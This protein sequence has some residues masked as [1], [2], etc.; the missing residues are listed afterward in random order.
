MLIGIDIGTT[1]CKA[2]LCDESAYTLAVESAATPRKKDSDGEEV[3]DPKQ[4]AALIYSLLNKLSAGERPE[5]IGITGMAE[6]G[7]LLDAKSGEPRSDLLFWPDSRGKPVFERIYNAGMEQD[8]FFST[9]LHDSYKYSIHKILML[10][11]KGVDLEGSVWLSAPAYAAF[12]LTGKMYDEYTLAARTYCFDINKLS[13]D[14][15]FLEFHNIPKDIFPPAYAAGQETGETSGNPW[16]GVPVAIG[17]HDHICA[18]YAQGI[19]NE[20]DIFLSMGTAAVLL[21]SFEKRRLSKDDWNLGYS[22]GLSPEKKRMTWLASIQSAGGAVDWCCSVLGITDYKTL[23]EKMND[24]MDRVGEVLFFP[25][26]SG[27]GAPKLDSSIRG[28][29][30]GLTARTGALDLVQAVYEGIAYEMRML[31]E[32]APS[33]RKGLVRAVGGGTRNRLFIRVLADILGRTVEISGLEQSA[34]AGAAL[35][36]GNKKPVKAEVKEQFF[37]SAA[38]GKIYEGMYQNAYLGMQDALRRCSK[39]L[40][41]QNK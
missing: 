22:F 26:L 20:D 7:I 19:E 3:C 16:R 41:Y 11:D 39:Q 24:R 31:L 27:S 13:Y 2:V 1:N 10:R 29:F 4:L 32:S 25:Y 17:G 21:G 35:L 12:L 28:G 6:G 23:D 38:R 36:A 14:Y 33:G 15:S 18:S 34:A 8:R 9:G 40:G 30:A 5:A 37:P